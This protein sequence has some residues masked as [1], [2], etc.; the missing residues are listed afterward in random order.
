[1]TKE[2]FCD[3]IDKIREVLQIPSKYDI[4]DKIETAITLL[5]E[6]REDAEEVIQ[7]EYD[8]GVNRGWNHEGM[9]CE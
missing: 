2:E 4:D 1:M 3:K 9:D 6:L 7:D 5:E 8:L